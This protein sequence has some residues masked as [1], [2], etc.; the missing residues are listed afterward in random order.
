MNNQWDHNHKISGRIE[1]GRATVMKISRGILKKFRMV[2]TF[3]WIR[4]LDIENCNH[5]PPRSFWNVVL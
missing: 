2:D 4:S 1:T 5:T 3:I